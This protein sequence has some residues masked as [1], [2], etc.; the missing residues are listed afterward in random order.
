MTTVKHTQRH[1]ICNHNK[2]ELGYMQWMTWA[3]KLTQKGIK[4][5]ICPVCKLW[6]FPEEFKA[7]PNANRKT[8]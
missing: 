6:L 4:Q 1:L 5:K 2:K 7:K 3:E 8:T